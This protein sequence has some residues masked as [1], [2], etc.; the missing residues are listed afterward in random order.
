MFDLAAASTHALG[1]SPSP[2][3]DS[4]PFAETG[5]HLRRR[6]RSWPPLARIRRKLLPELLPESGPGPR[7]G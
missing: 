3:H 4:P 5:R 6:S 1:M 7:W 2:F